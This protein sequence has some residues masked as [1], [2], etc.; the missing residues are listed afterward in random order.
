M[1]KA[2][3]LHFNNDDND[4]PFNSAFKCGQNCLTEPPAASKVLSSQI[5]RFNVNKAKI[6]PI[7]FG[8]CL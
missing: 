6:K 5:L 1:R 8:G 4:N 3:F 2:S 7:V